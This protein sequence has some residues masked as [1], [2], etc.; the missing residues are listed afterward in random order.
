MDGDHTAYIPGSG[1]RP[2]LGPDPDPDPD[3]DPDM[4]PD[5]DLDPNSDPDLDL[6]PDLDRSRS[7]EQARTRSA[8]NQVGPLATPLVWC[9]WACFCSS[10]Q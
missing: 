8:P 7:G 4:D 2:D 9:S 1:F 5:P 10:E 3:S 6:D